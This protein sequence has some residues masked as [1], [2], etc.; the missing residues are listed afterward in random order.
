M[1]IF[2]GVPLLYCL[3]ALPVVMLLIYFAV[4]VAFYTKAMEIITSKR[5]IKCWV[6]EVYLPYF[7]ARDP[8]LCSFEVVFD[9]GDIV[10]AGNFQKKVSVFII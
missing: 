10:D 9:E 1:F 2:L 4:Y 5:A 6:A 7:F 8:R 3:A